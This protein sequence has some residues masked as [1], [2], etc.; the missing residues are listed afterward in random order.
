LFSLL[1][2]QRDRE[3]EEVVGEL[4]KEISPFWVR[5]STSSLGEGGM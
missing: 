3:K 2:F 5:V 4:G 1:V